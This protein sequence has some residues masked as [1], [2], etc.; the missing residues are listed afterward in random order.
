MMIQVTG[1]L[2]LHPVP[3]PIEM[4]TALP[5]IQENKQMRKKK[6]QK[7]KQPKSMTTTTQT[8]KQTSINR[9]TIARTTNQTKKRERKN[10]Q[11]KQ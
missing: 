11:T 3:T 7:Q 8:W 9:P 6:K 1:K 2:E 4:K 5:F 10:K